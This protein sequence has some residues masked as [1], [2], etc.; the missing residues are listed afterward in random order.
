MDIT[1]RS[2]LL[3][4]FSRVLGQS[5]VVRDAADL[6]RYTAEPRGRYHERPLA[7]LRPAST[8]EVAAIVLLCREHGVAIVPQGGNTGLVGG[9][10]I[11]R[12]EHEV[13]LSLERMRSIREVD[14][15]GAS[16]IAEA[17][18]TLATAQAAAESVGL[19]F[20]MSLASEGTA[21]IGGNI[22][23]NAG[24]HL[25]VRY[26]NM[27][28][29]VLGLEVVLA[30]GRV[31]DGLT[32]LRK[33]NSGYDLNQLF[34]GSEGTL[35]IITAAS[36][37]LVSMPR[38]SMTAFIGVHDLPAT[39]TLLRLLRNH[40]GETVSALELMPRLA[41][42]FVLD[43]LPD[44]HDPLVRAYP[45]YLLL[46]CDTAVAGDWLQDACV[47]ALERAADEGVAADAVVAGDDT[48]ANSLWR[49]REAISPAQ[50]TGGV[51]LKH[52]ISV[53][54]ATIPEFV[55]ETCAALERQVPGI[56]PCVFGHIGDGNLHF[57]LSQPEDMAADAFRALEGDC[58]RIVF[59][60]VVRHRGSIA[61]EHGIGRL[62]AGELARRG[63]AVRL[64]LMRRLKR[65]LDPDDLLNPGKVLAPGESG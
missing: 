42:D 60:A 39:L 21:T 50:K 61:A 23:T 57:N 30:D 1:A 10:S 54:V 62:R 32:S 6:D 14:A 22:A 26:G 25:T 48:R 27:R 33:D 45:W 5:G 9:Q 36:L 65:A 17:G 41:L 34:I 53:P 55:A 51:S 4:A 12:P 64:D 44:A 43:Y 16:L 35:G 3:E 56:R 49:L 38:Q 8:Q 24:G 31:L 52:D 2:G 18:C 40:L 46:Q 47:Q 19:L 28:R 7:V 63:D 59:D 58:N 29:Q 13:I 20:P 37:N 11:D 15:D